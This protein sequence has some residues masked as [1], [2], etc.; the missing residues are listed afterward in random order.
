MVSFSEKARVGDPTE[1]SRKGLE[2]LGTKQITK[3]KTLG[4]QGGH[5][6]KISPDPKHFETNDSG[7]AIRRPIGGEE[8]RG[9]F[10][11]YRT[12]RVKAVKRAAGSLLSASDTGNWYWEGV[13]CATIF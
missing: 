4:L 1:E 2:V 9:G 11:H 10:V 3:R 12:A 5:E 8:A 13:Y 7:D 6:G